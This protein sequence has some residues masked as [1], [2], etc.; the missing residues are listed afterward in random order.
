MTAAPWARGADPTTDRVAT[1]PV[2]DFDSKEFPMTTRSST[3]TLVAAPLLAAALVVAGC[4]EI[5]ERAVEEGLE[6]AGG[7][8]GN[9]ELDLDNEDGSLSIE[10]SEGSFRIGAQD[11]PEDFPEEVPLPAELE[12]MS[13]MSFNEEGGTSF[14][15]NATT[16]GDATTVADELEAAFTDAGFTITGTS[17]MEADGMANRTFQFEGSDWSGNVVVVEN[18][19]D[20]IVNYTIAPTQG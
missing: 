16:P 17:Q 18:P 5:A 13:S 19:D 4:G 3:S 9:V 12:V 11:V 7:A 14:N 1:R 15:L 6:Q 2:A 20:T 8:S 10:S